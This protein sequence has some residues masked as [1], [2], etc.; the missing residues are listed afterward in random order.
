[1]KKIIYFISCFFL[2]MNCVGAISLDCPEVASP[3]EVIQCQVSDN[4]YIGI[5]ANY[6]FDNSFIYQNTKLNSDWNHYYSDVYGFS[7]GNV[8]EYRELSIDIDLKIDMNVVVNQNYLIKLYDIE[9]V[10]SDYK[11]LKLN[12]L[13]KSILVVSDINTLDDLKIDRGQVSPEFDKD[14]I[15]YEAVVNSDKVVIEAIPSDSEAKV[16]GALGEQVLNYG[17]N[18]FVIK[19]IS[20]RGNTR[21]YYLY[22]TRNLEEDKKETLDKEEDSVKKSSDFTLKHLSISEGK[23]DFKN[24]KFLYEVTVD[25]AVSK[26]EV[27]AV[28]NSD[29]AKVEIQNV[30]ELRIG[31][32]T[33]KVVV[34]AEDGTVGTYVIIVN[35]KEKLSSDATIKNLEV[36]GYDLAFQADVLEYELQI[37][38]EDKLDIRVELN[39]EKAKYKIIGNKN[40]KNNSIIKIKVVA[41]DGTELIYKIK[42]TRLNEANSNAITNYVKFIPLICFIVLI[43]VI[44]GVKIIRKKV[45]NKG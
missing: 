39:D 27:E 1:M 35:R 29:K 42:I 38:D 16:E 15:R 25:N 2:M 44:L 31:E 30:D 28:P 17:T 7:V 37:E 45:L 26:I 14:V 9:G 21:E 32:N 40:L 3:G 11:Y 22:I 10:T 6:Q 4:Q 34:T 33:I 41:E 12:D 20:V 5:K 43:I 8:K 24:D 19:V 13:E 23:I 36:I 18:T